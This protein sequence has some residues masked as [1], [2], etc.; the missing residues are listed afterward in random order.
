[1]GIFL[2]KIKQLFR[3]VQY[4]ELFVSSIDTTRSLG[5]QFVPSIYALPSLGMQLLPT[6][7][8]AIHYE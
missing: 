1:M 4:D 7:F 6:K 3:I 8:C 5:L 2:G